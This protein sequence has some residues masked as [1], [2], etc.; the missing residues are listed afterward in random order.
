MIMEQE[1]VWSTR[2]YTVTF[3]YLEQNVP[4]NLITQVMNMAKFDLIKV[5]LKAQ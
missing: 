5:N 3:N 1:K 4:L 2:Y